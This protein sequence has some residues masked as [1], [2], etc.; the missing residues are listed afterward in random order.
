MHEKI[1]SLT[2]SDLIVNI[3]S[4]ML[5]ETDL[6]IQIVWGVKSEHDLRLPRTNRALLTRNWRIVLSLVKAWVGLLVEKSPLLVCRRSSMRGRLANAKA[7]SIYCGAWSKTNCDFF[8]VIRAWSQFT[9]YHL[10]CP[11]IIM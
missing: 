1:N 9:N 4:K 10:V 7:R 6:K 5:E 2:V 8:L 3:N 11:C